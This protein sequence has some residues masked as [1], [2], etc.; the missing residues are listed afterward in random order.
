[1]K[2]TS[3]KGVKAP[4]CGW[5]LDTAASLQGDVSPQPGNFTICF[6][7]GS[8]L[9]FTDT[10]GSVRLMTSADARLV[11]AESFRILSLVRNQIQ[12]RGRIKKRQS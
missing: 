10:E 4:C 2:E 5:L 3:F 9:M 6:N 7:C 11:D 1:M 8:W 12:K